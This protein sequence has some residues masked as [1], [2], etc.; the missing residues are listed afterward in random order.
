MLIGQKVGDYGYLISFALGAFGA[1]NGG[2]GSLTRVHFPW[3]YRFVIIN[4]VQRFYCGGGIKP[5]NAL[6][7][8]QILGEYL[9]E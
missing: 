4:A 6:R 3:Y 7:T 1:L 2:W 8:E 5:W 9:F